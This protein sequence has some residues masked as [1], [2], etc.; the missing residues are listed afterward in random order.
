MADAPVP[1]P[2]GEG[3]ASGEAGGTDGDF[4][5]NLEKALKNDNHARDH[6]HHESKQGSSQL[7]GLTGTGG[8]IPIAVGGGAASGVHAHAAW[9]AHF[10][11]LNPGLLVGAV[12]VATAV[13]LTVAAIEAGDRWDKADQER[14]QSDP[15]YALARIQRLTA[16]RDQNISKWQPGLGWK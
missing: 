4:W 8:P 12:G 13:A 14:A 1:L 16:Q 3:G 9:T 15:A 11:I 10:G 5:G 6:H 2:S 7:G